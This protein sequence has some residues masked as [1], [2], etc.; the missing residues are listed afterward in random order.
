MWIVSIR[1]TEVFLEHETPRWN[2]CDE[3][4]GRDGERTL[5]TMSR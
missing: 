2:V 4:N 1:Y 5:G 3:E